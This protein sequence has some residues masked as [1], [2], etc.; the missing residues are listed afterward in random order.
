MASSFDGVDKH[1]VSSDLRRMLTALARKNNYLQAK[2][3][4]RPSKGLPSLKY[5]NIG[6]REG[7]I[8]HHLVACDKIFM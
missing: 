6:E 8:S 3:A 7:F 5:A 4:K 2:A 1:M